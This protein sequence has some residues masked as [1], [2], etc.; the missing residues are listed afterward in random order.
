MTLGFK[1]YFDVKK[2]QPTYFREKI[3]ASVI[4]ITEVKIEGTK[5]EYALNGELK[6]QPKL[7]TIRED[8]HNR[9]KPGMSIQMVYRG[10]KY[11]IKDHFNKNYEEIQECEGTQRIEIVYRS[12]P[13]FLW[14]KLLKIDGR[15]LGIS[16]IEDLALNDGFNDANHFF[17][18]FN[19]DFTGKIIHW[20]DLRY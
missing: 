6:F 8:K 10:P 16:E 7:H 15:R 5:K 13:K 9:W 20:T 2:T 3:W 1:E 18:Y 4:H 17:S 19:K 11:S 12:S 14:P